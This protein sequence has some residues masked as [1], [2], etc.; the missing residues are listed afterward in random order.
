MC[1]CA[2]GIPEHT[3]VC[4]CIA[5]GTPPLSLCLCAVELRRRLHTEEDR[6]HILVEEKAQLVS[7]SWMLSGRCMSCGVRCEVFV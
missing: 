5:C 1:V 4:H 2:R 7:R 6:M 3:L